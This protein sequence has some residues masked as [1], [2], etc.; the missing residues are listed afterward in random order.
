MLV[1]SRSIFVA[2]VALSVL[3]PSLRC[4]D[5]QMKVPR[6]EKA[7]CPVP[8][9]TGESVDC[10]LLIVPEH[11]G[12]IHTRTI[13]LPVMV[14][15]ST[16]ANPSPDPVVYLPGGPGLSSVDGRTSSKGNPFLAERDQILLEGRGNMFAQPSLA[17]P[18][19]NALRTRSASEP[20]QLS[21]IARCRAVLTAS[22]IDLDGYTS[23]ESADDLEDLRLLLGIRQW[24]LIG[25][26]YGTDLAQ[27]VLARHPQGI[28]SVLLDSVLPIDMNYD[29]IAAATLQRGINQMLDSCAAN[30]LCATRSP[31]L[32]IRLAALIA[33]A[34]SVGLRSD[35]GRTLRGRDIVYAIAA[36]LQQPSKIPELPRII[37][38]AADGKLS[39]LMPLLVES[40]SNYNWGL[41]L[42]IWCGEKMSFERPEL[43]A[44]QVA[45]TLGLGG[46]D[47]RTASAEMCAAWHVAP[48]D[49][50]A[51]RQVESSVPALILAGEFDPVTP[52][53]WGRSLLKKMPN[54][55]FVLV[56]GQSHG[57]MFNRCGGQLTLAFLHDPSAPLNLDCIMKSVGVD[58]SGR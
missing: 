23:A 20:E 17:C 40:T 51:H 57:A 26:S 10:G 34:D 22:G 37:I 43:V 4:A 27:V 12:S 18:E 44:G 35:D 2:A 48:T 11:R 1:L 38:D 28:R 53:A 25:Y 15:R 21:A 54:A 47:A 7:A 16:S 52:P 9:A 6:F 31:N 33:R 49:P 5:A 39:G 13:Q 58:F 14:F 3:L 30:P 46:A 32:R 8:V 56:P 41:R 45:P 24:N 55:R 29:E 19:L 50:S 42:S 36:T